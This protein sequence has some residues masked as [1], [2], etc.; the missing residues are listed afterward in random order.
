MASQISAPVPGVAVL[1]PRGLNT[2]LY[3]DL[4]RVAR[5]SVWAHTFMH[6]YALWLGPVV[7]AATVV[8]AYAVVWWRRSLHAAALLVLGGI[9][10]LAALGLNQLVG[11]AA[12]E[13]R[14][15]DAHPHALVLVARTNDYAF[16]SD[17]AVLAGG[18]LATVLLLIAPQAWHAVGRRRNGTRPTAFV[19]FAVS[20]NLVVGLFLC[21]ARVYVGA[22]YPGDV[23]AG[24]LFGMAVVGVLSL[25][26]ALAYAL[27]ESLGDSAFGVLVRRPRRFLS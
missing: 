12:R 7:L 24:L 17:H 5:H 8:L 4:N 23:V 27:A 3:L 25:A 9:G 6:A 2:R 14:P 10:T 22:H 21:F 11:H 18:L 26:R 15:Y 16:P 20:V 1:W 19:A 13:L